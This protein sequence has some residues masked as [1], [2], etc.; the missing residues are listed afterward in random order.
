MLQA[1]RFANAVRRLQSE[2]NFTGSWGA[3]V[4]R[5][6]LTNLSH[7][8][9]VL[10]I[11]S[12]AWNRSIELAEEYGWQPL[13]AAWP[14]GRLAPGHSLDLGGRKSFPEGIPDEHAPNPFPWES[15]SDETPDGSAPEHLRRETGA[16]EAAYAAGAGRAEVVT[17]EDALG[18]AD[19]LQQA[20]LEYE[21]E[22]VYK[23]QGT[24][25]SQ[26]LRLEARTRPSLG[27][28]IALMEFCRLGAFR[29]ESY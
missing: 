21:P 6:R 3:I 1:L 20:L 13:G 25:L 19:A 26:L 11:S 2:P 7:P 15:C 24:F 27:A 18:M 5:V 28:I 4:G 29:V 17:L 8:K 9:K 14:G 16:W 12:E 10:S 22:P 23:L